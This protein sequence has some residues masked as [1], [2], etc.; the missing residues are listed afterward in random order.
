MLT[1]VFL[2]DGKGVE[3]GVDTTADEVV[4]VIDVALVPEL[5]VTLLVDLD[6][7]GL[8]AL[9]L[10]EGV[11]CIMASTSLLSTVLAL[12][13]SCALSDFV[14]TLLRFFG[15]LVVC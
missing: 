9:S 2:R 12:T 13:V 7:F 10:R 8:V 6:F 4:A 1:T 15:S 5:S 14:V 3:G 11:G